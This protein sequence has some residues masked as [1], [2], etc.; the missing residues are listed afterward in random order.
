LSPLRGR[1]AKIRVSLYADDAT[2]FL[3]PYQQEVISLKHSDIFWSSN[4]AKTELGK[5]LGSSNALVSIWT[6]FWSYLLDRG[7]DSQLHI[8][9]SPSP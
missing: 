5:V 1:L 4:R 8:W 7:S 6:I 3:N 9:G 2:I